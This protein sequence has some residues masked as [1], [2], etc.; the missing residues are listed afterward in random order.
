MKKAM[1]PIDRLAHHNKIATRILIGAVAITF[2]LILIL[3][4]T[5]SAY[6]Y[7]HSKNTD[8]ELHVNAHQNV[9]H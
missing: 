5:L 3:N 6:S 9:K 4:L 1:S 2:F 8:R 7:Y